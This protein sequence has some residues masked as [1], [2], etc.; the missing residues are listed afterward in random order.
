MKKLHRLLALLLAVIL[1]ALAA[2]CT[3]ASQPEGTPG[4]TGTPEADGP[5]QSPA[6]G[7]AVTYTAEADGFA[8][9]VTVWVTV[10]GDTIVEVVA[11]GPNETQ[12]K[13]S[14]AIDEL[15]AQIVA[16]NGVEGVDA[17]SGA[18]VTANA[19]F[20]AVTAALEN[21]VEG[22]APANEVEVAY[23]AGTYTAQAFGFN[24]MVTVETTFSDDEIVEI[25]VDNSKETPYLRDLCAEKIPAEIIDHQ[26]LNVDVVTGA[27]WGSM[28]IIN[29]VADCVEQAS[30]PQTVSY[31]K[32][33]PS[34]QPTGEDADYEGYDLAVVGGGGSGLIA[35][36]VAVDAGLKVIVIEAA[37]RWGGVS[38]IAGGGTFAIGTDLQVEAGVYEEA[39][40]TVEEVFDQ[41][42]QEYMDTCLYQ[43]NPLMIRRYLQATGDAADFMAN[44]MGM[45][46]SVRGITAVNYGT[47]GE[48]YAPVAEKLEDAGATLLLSTRGEHL[49]MNDDGSVGGV[50]AVDQN[51]GAN[52]TVK[53]KAVLL[54]TGGSSNNTE[55]MEQY[56]PNYN[57]YYMN[58]GGSTANGDGV[59]MAWEVGAKRTLMGTQSHN[60]GLPLEYH[61]LFDFDITTG[62]CLYANLV[63]EPMLRINRETGRRIADE[64]IMY[65]PHYQGNNNMPTGGAVVIVDQATIDSLMENGSLTRPWRS[66]LYQN[67]MKEPDYTGLNLQEQ[68]DEV[69][70][71]NT[72][73]AHKADT[74]E[75]LAEAL[76]LDPE[77]LVNEVE[78][79]N[80]AVETGVDEE[81]GRAADTLVYTV[82]AGP[83]YALETKVRNLGTW[84]GISTDETLAVYGEDG[85]VIPGLYAAGLDALG[86]IG[87]SYFVDTTTLG[88]MTASGYMAGNSIV[89]YVTNN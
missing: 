37:D 4:A 12:G 52:V 63:Y 44:T 17:T 51:T 6:E 53:A 22:E 62:N 16:A 30:D 34:V 23:T 70:A 84:G 15:P 55:L 41:Y 13:G 36:S 67:P 72:P 18:T 27:T 87:I 19:V 48:R 25:S 75:E 81:F 61:D 66:N 76:G 88:W 21:K 10:E 14:V 42:M 29:A 56:A 24:T 3:P 82:S 33:I 79:Y 7:E 57:E 77:V 58:W 43:A 26:S 74:L 39:G 64:T 49:I 38:E 54:A 28:A 11:E 78:K 83:F 45:S 2:G 71:A 32:S 65:T 80:T 31:L 9:K 86:W 35:A 69:I 85:G 68:I 89:D 46:Y 73:Y 50:T 40:T 47:K 20:S 59:T 8:G 1:C 5:A 60:E